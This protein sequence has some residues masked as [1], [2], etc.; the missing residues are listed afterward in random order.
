MHALN[1]NSSNVANAG[2]TWRRNWLSAVLILLPAATGLGLLS[3]TDLPYLP[4][5]AALAVGFSLFYF[6]GPIDWHLRLSVT[7]DRI[8]ARTL[9][10]HREV[11]W[12]DV[13]L[14]SISPDGYLALTVRGGPALVVSLGAFRRPLCLLAAIRQHL[15]Q[16]H[17]VECRRPWR[18][19]CG[20][21][22]LAASAS[23][24]VYLLGVQPMSFFTHEGAILRL[25]T[26]CGIFGALWLTSHYAGFRASQY[27]YVFGVLGVIALAAL[28]LGFASGPSGRW[29]W[30]AGTSVSVCLTASLAVWALLFFTHRIYLCVHTRER[31]G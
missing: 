12:S 28:V 1:A 24:S 30:W 31:Q 27:R 6:L 21:A 3:E 22:A 23:C 17:M 11:R 16:D 20:L 19:A 2:Y 29:L 26:A 5:F 9:T 10:W 15:R 7:D 14:C 8:A 4:R 18:I 13:I 25:N